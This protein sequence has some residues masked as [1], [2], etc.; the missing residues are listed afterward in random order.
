MAIAKL[1]L[2]VGTAPIF[3]GS[4]EAIVRAGLVPVIFLNDGTFNP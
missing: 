1:I 4:Y 3:S 2:K